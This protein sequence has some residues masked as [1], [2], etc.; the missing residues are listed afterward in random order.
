M[1]GPRHH[2]SLSRCCDLLPLL[3]GLEKQPVRGSPPQ[4][5]PTTRPG[6]QWGLYREGHLFFWMWPVSSVLM[7][8]ETDAGSNRFSQI[9]VC[10]GF[11]SSF[12][13]PALLTCRDCRPQPDAETTGFHRLLHQ[14]LFV[15]PRSDFLRFLSPPPLLSQCLPQLCEVQPL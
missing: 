9:P 13:S 12:S 4:A 2:C 11:E 15:A 14:L 8:W 10:P 3:A 6:P 5:S 7:W 1:L